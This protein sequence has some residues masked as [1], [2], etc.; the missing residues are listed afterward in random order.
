MS[1]FHLLNRAGYVALFVLITGVVVFWARSNH[2]N[3]ASNR[4]LIHKTRRRFRRA[5]PRLFLALC[6]CIVLGG[7]LN[8]I[9]NGDSIE[10]R[11]PR[12]RQWLS[13]SGWF[14]IH[15]ADD[16]M[17]V[18][19]CNYEWLCGPLLAFFNEE[20]IFFI[21]NFSAY[22]LLPGLFFSFLRKIGVSGKVAWWWMW[23]LP[24]GFIYAMQASSVATDGFSATPA[25]AAVVLGMHGVA[26]KSAGDLWLSILAAGFL[27]GIKQ[28]TLPLGIT[29]IIPILAGWK[30]LLRRP[31]ITG[32]VV[33]FAILCSTIPITVANVHYTG[34]WKG[35]AEDNPYEQKSFFWGIV[36]N[37]A[38][39]TA[40]NLQPPIFPWAAEWNEAMRKF[41]TTPFGSHF[42]HFEMFIGLWR[43]PSEINAG[44]GCGLSLLLLLSGF[45]LVYLRRDRFA[46]SGKSTRIMQALLWSPLIAAAVFMGKSG[47]MQF[48]RYFAPYY[49]FL[50]PLLLV[51]RKS[52]RLLKFRFWRVA[53]YSSILLTI[54]LLMLSRQHPVWPAVSFTAFL[55]NQFPQNA[56]VAKVH[57]AYSFDH[58]GAMIQEALARSIP[59]NLPVIG[60]ASQ[61]GRIETY[62]WK[63]LRPLKVRRIIAGDPVEEISAMGIQYIVVDDTGLA[64]PPGK[65]I[66]SWLEQFQATE[67]ARFQFRI[68]SPESPSVTAYIVKLNLPTTPQRQGI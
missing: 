2:W 57:R 28:V 18:V 55:A 24:S 51:H 44:L 39:L 67:L 46:A 13:E 17:N 64:A 33:V 25:L 58:Q 30:I 68:V 32:L 23:L 7:V 26:R 45:G 4:S 61:F 36:G 47:L 14:W 41:V 10:Y 20:R 5:L 8:P 12:L 29:L 49:P 65:T 11:V 35:F 63:R 1:R 34:S 27:T 66:Q 60:Y 3:L 42:K 31:V 43:A 48:A 16:R 53:A 6:V 56:F 15:T 40:Q 37:T 21:V 62:L 38:I 52:Q 50:L 19:G 59:S 22:L 54:F 9:T